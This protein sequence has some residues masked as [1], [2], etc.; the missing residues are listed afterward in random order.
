MFSK[1]R[2]CG[3]TLCF[4]GL[5]R[6]WGAVGLSH[7]GALYLFLTFMVSLFKTSNSC[8]LWVLEIHFVLSC[9]KR[10]LALYLE[11]PFFTNPA[12]K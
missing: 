7:H 11:D 6:T 12:D 10:P 1:R 2:G 3:E 4:L 5:L 8:L 9:A